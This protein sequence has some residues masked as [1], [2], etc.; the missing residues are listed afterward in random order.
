MEQLLQQALLILRGVWQR[1]LPGLIA[2]WIAGVVGAIVVIQL[3]DQYE[4]S[5]RVYVDTD[6]V[7]RPLMQ[8][9][10]IQPDVGQRVQILSRTLISRPNVEK[11]IRMTDMDHKLQTP[12]QKERL[13]DELMATLKI[14]AAG[15][16]NLYS[17]NFR[18][19][20]PEQARKTVQALLSIFM[21][22]SLGEKRQDSV[23]AREFIEQQISEYEGKL[24]DAE[25]R[26]KEFRLRNL[27]LL[28]S[29]GQDY[30][31]K[32]DVVTN[33]MNAARNQLR[34]AEM[35]RDALKQQIEEQ[36]AALKV[37]VSDAAATA[38]TDIPIPEID[39]RLQTLKTELQE[40]LRKY[41]EE[42]P[43][44]IYSKRLIK[45]L[46]EDR[47]R[48]VAARLKALSGQANATGASTGSMQE[49]VLQQ[50]KV[51]LAEAQA[52]VAALRAR[53]TDAEQ[54]YQQLRAAAESIPQIDA[55]MAQLNRDYNVIKGQYDSLVT[56]RE[57]AAITGQLEEAGKVADFR[58]I[59]PPRVGSEPAAPN[60]L[61]LIALVFV[62][63][64]GVGAGV[65]FLVSQVLPTFPDGKTLRTISRRPL[66][67]TITMLERPSLI[68]ARRRRNYVFF[69]GLGSLAGSYVL[70][71]VVIYVFL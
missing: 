39:G 37:Q 51:G 63:A 40:L 47:K 1:R 71:A 38:P 16:N 43:D 25:N 68:K 54:R 41:T 62:A 70:L 60:R 55:E 26:L 36:E 2:A 21:E 56:R 66:L 69:G 44:V 19:P 42:H 6:S 11:L 20:S 18:D 24:R 67:G 59:D 49:V 50:L 28:S 14:Q 34:E 65:S 45:D 53:V 22:S 4:A 12:A 13:V 9:L 52:N 31:A 33:E 61:L 8:G 23:Q 15:T 10:A 35:S 27:G 64:L 58:I 17:I 57:S 48:E 30:F 5:A 3:P 7:L 46:E 32:M 29:S